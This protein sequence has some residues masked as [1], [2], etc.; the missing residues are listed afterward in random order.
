MKKYHDKKI[1]K[2]EFTIGDLL[3]LFNSRLCFF[4][5]QLMSKSTGPFLITQVFPHHAFELENKV[6]AKFNINAQRNKI[7]LGHAENANEV[8]EAKY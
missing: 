2:R 1:E 5:G 4:L 7:Y 8:G 6:G 3:F